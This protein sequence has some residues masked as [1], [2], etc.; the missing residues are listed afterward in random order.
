MKV[1]RESLIEGC[2][3]MG[4]ISY[5]ARQPIMTKKTVLTKEHLGVLEA[6][7]VKEVDVQPQLANGETFHPN[8]IVEKPFPQ[9]EGQSLSVQHS[10]V[11]NDYQHFY[12]EWQSGAVVDIPKLRKTLIPLLTPCLEDNSY[13]LEILSVGIDGKDRGH[14]ATT[15]AILSAFLGKKSGYSQGDA[16]Q[17]G[18]SGFLADC[19]MAKESLTSPDREQHPVLGY[20][21][22]K[23][24]KAVQEGVLFAVLQHHEY[25]NGSGYPLKLKGENLHPYAKIV[26]IIN[27]YYTTVLEQ[28]YQKNELPFKALDQ[29]IKTYFGKI[30]HRLLDTFC[31]ESMNLTLGLNVTL[32]N[33]QSGE[34][35]YIPPNM[36]TRPYV[37]LEGGQILTLEADPKLAIMKVL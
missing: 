17:V 31:L 7:L 14:Q 20:K 11:S 29:M 27:F 15:S 23:G 4:D 22:L 3:L 1:R 18:L 9:T 30:D 36:P 34:I 24:L 37:R 16:L 28:H 21:M 2:V 19:G 10:R 33:G 13:L 6:F 26:A 8:K 32:S 35:I 25:E 5:L 12:K